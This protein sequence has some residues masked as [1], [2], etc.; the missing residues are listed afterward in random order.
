MKLLYK[1]L[2][3]NS[4]IIEYV[5]GWSGHKQPYHIQKQLL[6]TKYIGT[7][8]QAL[9]RFN[10]MLLR[11]NE[12]PLLLNEFERD[13]QECA[14]TIKKFYKYTNR[15]NSWPLFTRRFIMWRLHTL[16]TKNIPLI[17]KTYTKLITKLND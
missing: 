13:L 6:L 15:L 8:D 3:E 12:H 10:T 16:G 7:L 17:K 9:S 1:Y 4:E 14:D 11:V 5:K 2:K